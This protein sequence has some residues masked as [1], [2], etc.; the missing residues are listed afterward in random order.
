MVQPAQLLENLGMSRIVSN[1]AFVGVFSTSMIA[2][3]LIDVSNLDP[4]I[5]VC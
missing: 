2:L 5:R 3:L 4:N 1:D